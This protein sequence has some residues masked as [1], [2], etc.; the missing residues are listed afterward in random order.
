MLQD[1]AFLKRSNKS[2]TFAMEHREKSSFSSFEKK[3]SDENVLNRVRRDRSMIIRADKLVDVDG[4][5]TNTVT[6][7]NYLGDWDQKH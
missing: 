5:K 6:M 2:Y 7:V 4:K 1:P 3:S